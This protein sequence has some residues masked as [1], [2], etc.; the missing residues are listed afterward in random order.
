MTWNLALGLSVSLNL[1]LWVRSALVSW[2]YEQDVDSAYRQ[3]R[4]EGWFD[5][6]RHMPGP[7]RDKDSK[8][9]LN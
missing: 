9:F 2:R 3:G 4:R 8:H 7:S 6:M 5:A 1:V